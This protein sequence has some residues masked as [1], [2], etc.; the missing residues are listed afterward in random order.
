MAM[1]NNQMVYNLEHGKEKHNSYISAH[2]LIVVSR[3]VSSFNFPKIAENQKVGV[4]LH[5]V[6][7]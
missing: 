1:L 4:Y 6:G 5:V 3:T 2:F 7:H